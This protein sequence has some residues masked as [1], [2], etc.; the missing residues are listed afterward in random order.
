MSPRFIALGDLT[1]LF[2]FALL[3]LAS[4]EHEVSAAA[5]ARTFLPFAASWLVVAAVAGAFAPSTD[6]APVISLRTGAAYALAGVVA[7]IARSIVF[8]RTLLNAFFVIALIG[9]G[10]FLFGWRAAAVAWTKR[11]PTNPPQEATQ[12]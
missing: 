12:P 4:H 11:R 5:L 8:D 2:A 3:G 7:L 10:L 9:N 1:A 6:G